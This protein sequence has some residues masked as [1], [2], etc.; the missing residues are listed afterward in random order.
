[1]I[2]YHLAYDVYDAYECHGLLQGA[3]LLGGAHD[4]I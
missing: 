3:A 1:M 2:A 4:I